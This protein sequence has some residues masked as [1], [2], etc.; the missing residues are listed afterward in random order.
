MQPAQFIHNQHQQCVALRFIDGVANPAANLGKRVAFG[1]GHHLV[2]DL[3][4]ER[5]MGQ[6]QWV[7][8]IKFLFDRPVFLR[9]AL[10]G[11]YEK[12]A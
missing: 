4:D 2:D 11:P 12:F 1:S 9:G 5:S 10:V 8:L 3:L 7:R 6:T